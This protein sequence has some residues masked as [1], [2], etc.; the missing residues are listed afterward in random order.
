MLAWAHRLTAYWFRPVLVM[1]VASP[2]RIL[3]IAIGTTPDVIAASAPIQYLH[4]QF[5]NAEITLVASPSVAPL[6]ER[7]PGVVAVFPADG[8]E[9]KYRF[10]PSSALLA[11]LHSFAPE[12]VVC[13]T[14]NGA[15]LTDQID[16]AWK[17]GVTTEWIDR[18]QRS[19]YLQ[20]AFE[21]GTPWHKWF[22]GWE[23]RFDE[24]MFPYL[25]A[26]EPEREWGGEQWQCSQGKRVLLLANATWKKYRSYWTLI[27]VR[28]QEA[29]YAPL[30]TIA[31]KEVEELPDE[32]YFVTDFDRFPRQL[33]AISAAADAIIVSADLA[34]AIAVASG[35]PTA[36]LGV[37]EPL[38]LSDSTHL[39]AWHNDPEFDISETLHYLEVLFSPQVIEPESTTET[40]PV[41]DQQ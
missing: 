21:P 14:E 30:L 27:A 22:S 3:V 41:N 8:N 39:L 35:V 38:W 26:S 9:K 33:L 16:A 11:T 1:P 4:R 20:Q 40:V 7:L 18:Q 28:L 19:G 17:L 5:S 25:P 37:S 29:G 12:L 10:Q 23:P 31:R 36:R 13:A 15:V 6:F 2:Q 34:A 32:N 24:P